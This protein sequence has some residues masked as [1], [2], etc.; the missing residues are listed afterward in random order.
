MK[1]RWQPIMA[2]DPAWYSIVI[3]E[4]KEWMDCC[5]HGSPE[6][7]ER[8]K[9]A[10]YDF[11]EERL[12]SEQIVLGS[13]SGYFDRD[14]KPIDTIVLHHTS[15]PLGL[16]PARLSA[17][18][19]IRLYAP[20]FAGPTAKEDRRLKGQPVFSGHARNGLQV[21]WPYHWMIRSNGSAERLL[22]D[23]EVGW[24]AGNWNVN[25]RSIAIV[26]DNDYEHGRPSERELRVI[27]DVIAIHYGNVS[28]QRVLGHR[29]VNA[30][31][32]CPSEL[33]L[34][35]KEKGWKNDLLSLLQKK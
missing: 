3:P 25:C 13:T 1:L 5:D 21:F 15:N 2:A 34:D 6:L 30:R 19:L 23:D 8:C 18:E 28:P 17:I 27:R 35:G 10:L 26:L 29:E 32:T 24:H 31:T 22:R 11:I 33:F 14:R 20:Y 12:S 4:L 7:R 9:R 16:S